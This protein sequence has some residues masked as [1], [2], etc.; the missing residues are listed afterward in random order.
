MCGRIS[1]PEEMVKGQVKEKTVQVFLVKNNVDGHLYITDL[2]VL[3]TKCGP[4]AINA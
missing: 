4:G 3:F 1:K 2:L